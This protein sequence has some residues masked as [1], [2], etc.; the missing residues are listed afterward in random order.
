[1]EFA[2]SAWL[3][4]QFNAYHNYFS[5]AGRD[6]TRFL[7]FTS[8]WTIILSSHHMFFFC[9]PPD[10]VLGSMASHIFLHVDLL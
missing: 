5:L 2:I 7:L 6:C 4:S 8:T 1:M 9:P 10:S 3:T